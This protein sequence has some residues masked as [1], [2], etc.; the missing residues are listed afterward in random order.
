M[1]LCG[2][3]GAA[4]AAALFIAAPA[5]AGTYESGR[6][7]GAGGKTTKLVDCGLNAVAIGFHGRKGSWID[8]VG[9]ICRRV[10]SNGTLGSTFTRTPVGGPGGYADETR[11]GGNR[12]ISKV[13]VYYG[14][15]VNSFGKRCLEWD[16]ANRRTAAGAFKDAASAFGNTHGTRFEVA[17]PDKKPL[18]ALR[19]RYGT[20]VDSVRVICRDVPKPKKVSPLIKRQLT[21]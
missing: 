4:L 12:V 16:A 21:R 19:V 3:I 10:N 8:S 9:L 11:C 13:A 5:E 17:C 14:S 1:K 7:G 2:V 15:F 20:Y 18:Q 6:I